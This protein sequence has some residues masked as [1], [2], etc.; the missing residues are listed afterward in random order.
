MRCPSCGRQKGKRACPALGRTICTV[1][2][3]T[4][5]I[6]E[7]EC[8]ADCVYLASARE[9]PAAVVRRQQERDVARLMPTIRHLT[10]RQYQLFFLFHSVMARHRP[11]GFSRLTD[12][13]AAEA[14]AATASTLETAARGVIYEHVPAGRPAQS[15]AAAFTTLRAEIRKQGTVYDSEAALALRAIE[16]GARTVRTADDGPAAYL[17]LV[18]RLLQVGTGPEAEPRETSPSLIVP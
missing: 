3:G 2:C 12:E 10:E 16:Q 11:E 5:R 1:C 8:P 14:A 4:K 18:A 6:V 17:E 13:D 7:I 9:H 15:L